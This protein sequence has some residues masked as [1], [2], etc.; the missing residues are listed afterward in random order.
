MILRRHCRGHIRVGL[1]RGYGEV[2]GHDRT[3]AG[4]DGGA[5]GNKLHAIQAR[6][7]AGYGREIE[8]RVRAGIAMAREMFRGGKAA[9]FLDAAHERRD[10]FGDARRIFSEGARVNDRIF[11]IA[12]DVGIGRENPGHA[13]GSALREP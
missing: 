11:G 5:E 2:S 7:V 10:E 12:V 8:V 4:R 9:V 1:E 3:H 6:P 13:H